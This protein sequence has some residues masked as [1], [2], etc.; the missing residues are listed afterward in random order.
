M[1]VKHAIEKFLITICLATAIYI[2]IK[3]PCKTVLSCHKKI[4]YILV[5]MPVIFVIFN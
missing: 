4:F 3:C 2:T 5:G 1:V